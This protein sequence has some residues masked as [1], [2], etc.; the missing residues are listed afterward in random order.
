[1]GILDKAYASYRKYQF[2][3]GPQR[4]DLKLRNRQAYVA[5]ARIS[6]VGEPYRRQARAQADL[7]RT[8]SRHS[9][10]LPLGNG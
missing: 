4:S 6:T 3:H 8:L 9:A 2:T 1:M 10:G 7:E 5:A